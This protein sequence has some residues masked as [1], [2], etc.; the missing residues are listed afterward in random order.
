MAW[1]DVSFDEVNPGAELL[2]EAD[3]TFMVVSGSRGKFDQEQ[4][5]IR[6][7]IATPGPYQGQSV[8]LNYPNPD[9]AGKGVPAND[10]RN[11]VNKAFKSFINATQ[12]TMA[13]GEHPV[14]FINR[15]VADADERNSQIL[16]DARIAHETFPDKETGEPVTRHKVAMRS[17]KPSTATVEV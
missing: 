16:I 15:I 12:Q 1:T 13:P 17:V 7:S 2:P 6:L 3:F 4:L 10:P 5:S 14:D 8:Y 11:W 9:K